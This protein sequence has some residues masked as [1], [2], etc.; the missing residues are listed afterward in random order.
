MFCRL[1]YAMGSIYIRNFFNQEA[2]DQAVELVS[3][4]RGEFDKILETIDWMDDVTRDAATRKA[5]AIKAHIGFPK[6]LLLDD[7]LTEHYLKVRNNLI[8]SPIPNSS[9]EL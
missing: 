3:Y 9:T 1:S 7:K 2:K 8:K 6:E 5:Q 4:I